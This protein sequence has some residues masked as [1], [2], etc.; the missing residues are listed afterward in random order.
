[1]NGRRFEEKFLLGYDKYSSNMCSNDES[2][3]Y[4]GSNDR[5]KPHEHKRRK[6]TQKHLR[7]SYYHH[8]K[9]TEATFLAAFMWRRPLNN[10]ALATTTHRKPKKVSDET[11]T[12]VKV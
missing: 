9:C 6:G 7:K 5:D 4:R 8:I 12:Q 3:L 11:D 10:A 2:D 1:M